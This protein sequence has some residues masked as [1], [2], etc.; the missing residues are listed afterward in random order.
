[1]LNTRHRRIVRWGL[2]GVCGILLLPVWY[3]LTWLAVSRAAG[4]GL[5]GNSTATFIRPAFLPLIR[6][7]DQ[8]RPGAR[9]LS[10]LWWRTN[11]LHELHKAPGTYIQPANPLWRDTG[12]VYKPTNAHVLCPNDL[13]EIQFETAIPTDEIFTPPAFD[14]WQSRP[15]IPAL[16][17]A[18]SGLQ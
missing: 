2:L 7:C 13:E 4:D 11:P 5:I 12:I 1:M 14:P 6:Y 10:E 8:P 18:G 15:A 9:T 17:P 3:V 16:T